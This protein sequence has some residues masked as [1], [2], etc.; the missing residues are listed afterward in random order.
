LALRGFRVP[1]PFIL[2]AKKNSAMYDRD[3]VEKIA[4]QGT[5]F[6]KIIPNQQSRI[7]AGDFCGEHSKRQPCQPEKRSL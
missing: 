6:L 4:A 2:R 3:Y 1:F 7:R 5:K